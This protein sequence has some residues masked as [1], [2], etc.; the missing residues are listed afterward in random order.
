MCD[1][2]MGCECG[3]D[4]ELHATYGTALGGG[5]DDDRMYERECPN[6]ECGYVDMKEPQGA[7]AWCPSCHA[8]LTV[9]RVPW[10]G[11]A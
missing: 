3:H 9:C 7:C 2:M 11:E 5:S 4:M 6:P 10:Q 1:T 8:I